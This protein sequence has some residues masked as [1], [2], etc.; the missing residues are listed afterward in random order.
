MV[1]LGFIVLLTFLLSCPPY[2]KCVGIYLWLEGFSYKCMG[3]LSKESLWYYSTVLLGGKDRTRD[4]KLNERFQR[5]VMKK[6]HN[7]MPI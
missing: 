5:Q 6:A 4:L 2:F 3:L 7:L 1:K